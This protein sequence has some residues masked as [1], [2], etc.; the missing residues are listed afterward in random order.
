MDA[1]TWNSIIA[2]FSDPHILQTWHWGHVKSH[3]GWEPIYRVW[4][5]DVHPD[6]AALILQRTISLG[7]FAA[8]LRILYSPKGP[9]IRDWGNKSLVF[10]VL[11]DFRDLTRKKGAIFIK[12]D[13]DVPLGTGLP[14]MDNERIDPLGEAVC[15]LLT[16]QGWGYSDE[17]IQF[18]NTVLIDL[19]PPEGEILARMKQK[20]RYNIRLAGRKGVAI[21]SCTEGDL[22][23][24]YRMYAETSLRDGFAIRDER[25]YRLLWGTFMRQGVE[26]TEGNPPPTCEPL[27]ADIKGDPVAAVVIFRFAGKAYYMHGMSRP[28]HRDKM[29]NYLLQ[30][31]AMRRAKAT[32]C[33]TYDLWGAP[34][35][36]EEDDSMW[37]VY[38]FKRGLGGEVVRT[39]GA[40][41]LPTRP[42]FY[43]LYYH[44]L[45]RILKIM[46][47]FGI[48][49]TRRIHEG[50]QE[51]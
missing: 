3:F 35:A 33:K 22:G 17:Q 7:G 15:Q 5:D 1:K 8:P 14:G 24:L 27:V 43:G 9:L 18:R 40:Y 36:F 32:G 39:I 37:G 6:A 13:P 23:D 51:R 25:Y 47:N 11:D 19:N 48:S 38:R 16:S 42:L 20:T 44:A 45:P 29:P 34:E 41:D 50:H 10:Q 2:S 12:I 26:A 4:G 49:R 31:E 46:R 21:K 30:W 28:I